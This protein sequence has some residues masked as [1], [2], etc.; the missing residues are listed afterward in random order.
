MAKTVKRILDD[1][2]VAEVCQLREAGWS[3]K[4]ISLAMEQ[5]GIAVSPG[6]IAWTCLRNGADLPARRRQTHS[7][8]ERTMVVKRGDHLVRRYTA[9]EDRQILEME[10]AGASVAS[11]GRRLGRKHNSI[12]GRL[13]ALARRQ[14]RSEETEGALS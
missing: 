11:I 4:R 10:A 8:S 14:A 2:Q 9:E 1:E 12:L 5:R 3:L 7:F 13:A 6:A